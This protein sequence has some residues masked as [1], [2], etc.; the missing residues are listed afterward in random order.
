M[1]GRTLAQ[2]LADPTVSLRQVTTMNG[3]T[4]ITLSTAGA[5][6]RYVRLQLAGTAQLSLAEVQVQGL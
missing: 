1:T 6:G 3:A 4:N 5:Q 2:L